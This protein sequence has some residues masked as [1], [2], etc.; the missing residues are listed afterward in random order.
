MKNFERELRKR[1]KN[2][3]TKDLWHEDNIQFPRLIAELE[4]CGAFTPKVLLLLSESMNLSKKDILNI[5]DRA[6]LKFDEIKL[7]V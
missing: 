5:V 3:T 6:M 4:Y 1:N 2:L 7:N